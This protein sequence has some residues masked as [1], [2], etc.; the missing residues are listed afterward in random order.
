MKAFIDECAAEWNDYARKWKELGAPNAIPPYPYN[1]SNVQAYLDEET[2]EIE[3]Q[4]A[5]QGRR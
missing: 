3:A 5:R 4:A 2:K 1:Y